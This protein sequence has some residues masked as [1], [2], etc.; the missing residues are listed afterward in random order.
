[1]T[2]DTPTGSQD[3]PDLVRLWSAFFAGPLAWTFNQGVGYVMMKPVCAGAANYVLWLIAA[4][5]LGIVMAGGWFAWRLV[6]QPGSPQPG[7]GAHV[8]DRSGF[9]GVLAVSFNGLIG[10]LIMTSTIPQFI[11]TPCE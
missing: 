6:R 2:A 8:T 10:L 4:A 7:G 1:V 9:L 3:T 5:S 11:L